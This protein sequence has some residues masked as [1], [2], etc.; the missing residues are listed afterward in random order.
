M[1]QDSEVDRLVKIPLVTDMA[2]LLCLK[3][4]KR[5]SQKARLTRTGQR[6]ISEMGKQKNKLTTVK[7]IQALSKQNFKQILKAEDYLVLLEFAEEF[8]R[9]AN[10]RLVYPTPSAVE[11]LQSCLEIQRANNLLLAK[12]VE[13]RAQ[14]FDLLADVC[15]YK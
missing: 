2:N 6:F 11:T 14:G 7:E 12:Y 15:R 3:P 1:N 9:R 10:F 4:Y 8:S 13:W 5:L